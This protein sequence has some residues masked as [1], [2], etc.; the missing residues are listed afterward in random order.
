VHPSE[1]ARVLVLALAFTPA[2]LAFDRAGL[3]LVSLTQ[4]TPSYDA[5]PVASTAA[6]MSR[7]ATQRSRAMERLGL[8]SAASNKIGVLSTIAGSEYF[9]PITVGNQNFKVIVDTGR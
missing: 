9:V 8:S 1:M 7:V 2:A 3:N 4:L 6:S 5:L